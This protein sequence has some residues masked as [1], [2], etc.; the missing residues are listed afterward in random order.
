MFGPTEDAAAD[1]TSAEQP[2][3][4]ATAA[5]N[6]P[7]AANLSMTINPF[8]IIR[9]YADYFARKE[10]KSGFLRLIRKNWRQLT[11]LTPGNYLSPHHRTTAERQELN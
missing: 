7:A 10:E 11:I 8:I 6:P 9:P 3:N 1:T 5:A 4:D 2:S